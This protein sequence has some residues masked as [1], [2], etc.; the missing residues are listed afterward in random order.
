MEVSNEEECEKL[1]SVSNEVFFWMNESFEELKS[2]FKD[3]DSED[4]LVQSEN[5]A[6]KEFFEVEDD[7]K[8]GKMEGELVISWVWMNGVSKY[9]RREFSLEVR[10]EVEEKRNW[11]S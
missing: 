11:L 1:F 8:E 3:K 6:L 7:L 4:K 2:E 5:E 10:R 9:E